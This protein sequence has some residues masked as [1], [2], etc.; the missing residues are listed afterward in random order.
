MVVWHGYA[1]PMHSCCISLRFHYPNKNNTPI[2]SPEK[3]LYSEIDYVN[4]DN[5]IVVNI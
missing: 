1:V 4:V 3:E 5:K 2:D